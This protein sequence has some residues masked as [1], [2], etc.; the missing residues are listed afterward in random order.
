MQPD[1][2]THQRPPVR[3]QKAQALAEPPSRLVAA[4][5]ALG[6]AVAEQ[7]P[8]AELVA[9]VGED[10][11]RALDQ[12]GRFVMVDERRRSGEQRLGDVEPRRRPE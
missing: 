5:V 6:G 7:R 3:L 8:H 2:A 9:G 11:E 12:L 1:D 4:A 10:V